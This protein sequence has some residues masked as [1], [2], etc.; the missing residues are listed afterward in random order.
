MEPP[1]ADLTLADDLDL[2]HALCSVWIDGPCAQIYY[3]TR[4]PRTAAWAAREVR[5]AIEASVIHDCELSL[6]HVAMLSRIEAKLGSRL[7]PYPS[8]I[9]RF[10]RALL[11]RVRLR[12]RPILGL[13]PLQSPFG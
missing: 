8:A 1:D 12:I 13:L 2:L 3:D 9:S 7:R 11:A 10:L 6:D 5:L 4:S